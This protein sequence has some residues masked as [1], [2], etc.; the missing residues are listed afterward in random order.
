MCL[1]LLQLPVQVIL[2]LSEGLYLL[3][4]LRVEHCLLLVE[5]CSLLEEGCLQLAGCIALQGDLE[6]ECTE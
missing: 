2:L 5:L 1:E 6:V 3:L 4:V